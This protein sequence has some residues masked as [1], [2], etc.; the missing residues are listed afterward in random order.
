MQDIERS[1]AVLVGAR[2]RTLEAQL[3]GLSA[4]ERQKPVAVE[5]HGTE[6]NWA[7]DEVADIDAADS[8]PLVQINPAFYD[9]SAAPSVPQLI[10]ICLPGLQ[11]NVDTG[12]ERYAGDTRDQEQRKAERR[13]HDAV[14]IRDNLDW[15]ALEALVRR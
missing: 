8:D 4:A 11:G 9:K 1:G 5:V 2:L 12:Y 13:V 10:W 6:W 15:A 14:L 3:H 7:T